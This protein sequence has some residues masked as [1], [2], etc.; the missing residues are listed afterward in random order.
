MAKEKDSQKYHK[1]QEEISESIVG[2]YEPEKKSSGMV[3]LV[4]RQNRTYELHIGKE[5]YTFSGQEHKLVQRSV[6]DHPDFQNVR[7]YFE[8]KE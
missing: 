7:K 5:V 1:D 3:T 4:F 6:I 2:K 8:V